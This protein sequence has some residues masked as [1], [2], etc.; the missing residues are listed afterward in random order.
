ML[1]FQSSAP[2]FN[3]GTTKFRGNRLNA[4]SKASAWL[5]RDSTLKTFRLGRSK[6]CQTMYT[7]VRTIDLSQR[8]C[9]ITRISSL[10]FTLNLR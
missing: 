5:E 9:H 10:Y 6:P 7:A 2:L 8:S 4:A 3:S 1:H